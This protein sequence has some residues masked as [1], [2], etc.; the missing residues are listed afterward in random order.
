MLHVVS[1][2]GRQRCGHGRLLG[3]LLAGL[4]DVGTR[5]AGDVPASAGRAVVAAYGCEAVLTQDQLAVV[6]D[7]AS[8]CLLALEAE[9]RLTCIGA[10]LAAD[11]RGCTLGRSVATVSGSLG[12]GVSYLIAELRWSK[13]CIEGFIFFKGYT[14]GFFS[15]CGAKIKPFI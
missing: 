4:A 15:I 6:L 8:R 9:L 3:G 11:D 1:E 5:L 14:F 13:V 10:E 7:E 2:L 12:C